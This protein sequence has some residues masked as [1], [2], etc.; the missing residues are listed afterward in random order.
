M[1][2]LVIPR[3]VLESARLSPEELK[4]DLA[5]MLYA[6]GRLTLAQSA[7]L[8]GMDRYR[9]QQL[10][11]SRG[12]ALNYDEGDLQDDLR[13]AEGF[14]VSDADDSPPPRGEAP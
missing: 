7:R 6:D 2:D 12:I 8:A 1:T 11:A 14:F 9:F 10:L 4:R 3:A 13:T 5:A